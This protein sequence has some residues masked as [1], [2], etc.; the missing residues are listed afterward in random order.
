MD[1]DSVA[2]LLSQFLS[3][4]GRSIF[5]CLCDVKTDVT[6]SEKDTLPEIT[7]KA[8]KA[9][10]EECAKSRSKLAKFAKVEYEKN[11]LRPAYI[12]TEVEKE[13]EEMDSARYASTK[14][15]T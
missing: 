13:K 11:R 1:P 9:F 6:Q 12:K 10:E 4:I 3:M 8:C 5:E 2:S 14:S 7:L 15:R